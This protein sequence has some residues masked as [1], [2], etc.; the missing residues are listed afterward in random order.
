ML[1]SAFSLQ[2]S[3]IISRKWQ[4]LNLQGIRMDTLQIAIPSVFFLRQLDEK[5]MQYHVYNNITK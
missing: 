5:G 1:P 3:T 4:E 2:F